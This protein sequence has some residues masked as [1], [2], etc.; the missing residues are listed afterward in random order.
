MKRRA[1]HK[2]GQSGQVG[3]L[4]DGRVDERAWKRC[5]KCEVGRSPLPPGPSA[6]PVQKRQANSSKERNKSSTSSGGRGR[7]GCRL[8][9]R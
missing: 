9:S 7:A 8:Q 4:E 3:K 6:R 5:I 2:T 1:Y